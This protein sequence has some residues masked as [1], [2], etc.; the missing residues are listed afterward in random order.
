MRALI[1]QKKVR[2][3]AEYKTKW[4]WLL[5]KSVL[6]CRCVIWIKRDQKVKKQGFEN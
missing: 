4:R 2:F 6:E 3:L 1:G 5:Q